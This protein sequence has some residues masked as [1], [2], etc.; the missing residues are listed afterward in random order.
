[1]REL[2]VEN[3]D[4]HKPIWITEMNWNAPPPDFPNKQFGFVTPE[5]QA[6][7]AVLAYQRAQR[8]W[9]WLGVVNAWF[10]KRATDLE[11]D[12]AMYYFRLVEPDFAPMPVYYALQDH[13][14][15]AEARVLYPG[16]H[17]EDHWALAFGG[18]WETVSDPDAELGSYRQAGDLQSTLAFTFEG[19]GL[20]LRSGPGAGGM[21][22]YSL[23][24]GAEE[25]VQVG[26]GAQVELAQGL[27]RGPHSIVVRAVSTPLAVDSLTIRDQ[28]PIAPWLV[29]GGAV[30]AIGL[31]AMLGVG[32][33]TRRRRWY[34]RSRA[35]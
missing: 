30:V 22:A 1:L 4:A 18:A 3:G 11:Q 2:M 17:Q 10:F 15:S 8:E 32:V 20:W 14:H 12:Q 27:P 6:R 13:M 19:A 31:L 28:H 23:D 29:A 35:G 16:V 34:Q 7:Y 5:Q 21:V 9:P 33:A 26:A 25:S 24:G